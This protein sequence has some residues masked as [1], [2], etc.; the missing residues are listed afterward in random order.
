MHVKLGQDVFYV[1]DA[2]FPLH[3][4]GVGHHSTHLAAKVVHVGPNDVVN[5]CVF[6]DVVGVN[7]TPVFFVG[8]VKE[9]NEFTPG[10]YH[11]FHSEHK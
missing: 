3:S 8:D 6:K 10:T 2:D 11:T 4:E 9:S 5:L 1:K 7:D